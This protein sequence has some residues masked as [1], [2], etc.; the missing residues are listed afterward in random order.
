MG[1]TKTKPLTEDQSKYLKLVETEHCEKIPLSKIHKEF[2]SF[3]PTWPKDGTCET[4]KWECLVQSKKDTKLTPEA[5]KLYGFIKNRLQIRKAVTAK[6]LATHAV[7]QM[8]VKQKDTI[9][10]APLE[11]DQSSEDEDRL[12]SYMMLRRNRAE[13]E[14]IARHTRKK[15]DEQRK[16]DLI[17]KEK[18][19]VVKPSQKT[20]KADVSSPLVVR[21]RTGATAE[22]FPQKPVRHYPTGNG[23][24]TVP[25]HSAFKATDLHMLRKDCPS[26]PEDIAKVG[27]WLTQ[28]YE[29]YDCNPL[30]LL[31]LARAIFPVAVVERATN[32]AGW[33]GSPV[34]DKIDTLMAELRAHYPPIC[35]WGAIQNFQ[36]KT[37]QT[38]HEYVSEAEKLFRASSGLQWEHALVPFLNMLVQGLPA[39]LAYSLKSSTYDWAEKTIPQMTS[40]IQ[41]HLSLQEKKEGKNKQHPVVVQLAVP[42]LTD[43]QRPAPYAPRNP[44]D[45]CFYCKQPG[46]WKDECPNRRGGRGRGRGNSFR[47]FGFRGFQRGMGRGRGML[48]GNGGGGR[49]SFQYDQI[50][51][52]LPPPQQYN[53]QRYFQQHHEPVYQQ[54]HMQASAQEWY[55]NQGPSA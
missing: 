2:R 7:R 1:N 23:A 5:I 29:I 36:Y 19:S 8:V 46:H 28:T 17:E 38:A 49:H 53:Q 4:K 27:A 50:E 31:Q 15:Q 26:I 43:M 34:R 22:L 42:N 32:L 18:S 40:L 16:L 10:S 3:C 39:K 21:Q 25:I 54:S 12:N 47:G 33:P 30:D 6:Q 41:H 14:Q 35:D 48:R 51:G 24:D 11:D 52:Q 37:G 20:T 45:V 44:E 55:P 9:P 13:K